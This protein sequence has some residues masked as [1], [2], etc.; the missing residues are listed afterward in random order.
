MGN[1]RVDKI[2]RLLQK[3]ISLIILNKV[4]DPRIPNVTISYVEVSRDINYAKVFC[5]IYGDIDYQKE[6]IALLQKSN[7]F[8]RKE[9]SRAASFK[10]TPEINFY[11]DTRM[12]DYNKIE[13]ILKKVKKE[14][15][16]VDI[17]EEDKNEL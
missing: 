17:S 2:G 12:N 3:E 7:K 10:K 14:I 11:V 6:V 13:S 5:E 1:S 15:D 4:R 16:V 9:V 8:I